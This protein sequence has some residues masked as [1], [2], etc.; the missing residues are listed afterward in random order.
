MKEMEVI[1]QGAGQ[2]LLLENSDLSSRKDKE[3]KAVL[4]KDQY[5]T[6][7]RHKEQIRSQMRS[8]REV[9]NK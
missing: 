9:T 8:N 3:V 7:L 6:Y 4:D 2:W 1:T 5:K